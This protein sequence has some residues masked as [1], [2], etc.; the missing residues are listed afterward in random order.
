M[1]L[2]RTAALIDTLVNAMEFMDDQEFTEHAKQFDIDKAAANEIYRN[3]W[4]VSAVDRMNWDT[5]E[6][7]EWL[8][9]YQG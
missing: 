6:W 2:D 7:L 4:E 8:E 9:Q 3:Y 5:G 1:N